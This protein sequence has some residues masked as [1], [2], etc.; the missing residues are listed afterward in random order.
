[1]THKKRKQKETSCPPVRFKTVILLFSG[2]LIQASRKISKITQVWLF[3][4]FGFLLSL[5]VSKFHQFLSNINSDKCWPS[6]LT[7][8]SLIF[9]NILQWSFQKLSLKNNVSLQRWEPWSQGTPKDQQL[10]FLFLLIFS[11]KNTP[12]NLLTIPVT[13]RSGKT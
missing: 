1:M 6:P 3:S 5:K 9:L 12:K 13:W 11:K 2:H 10:T 8:T 4:G 7:L